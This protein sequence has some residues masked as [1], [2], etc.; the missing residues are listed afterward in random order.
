MPTRLIKTLLHAPCRRQ[1]AM[2]SRYLVAAIVTLSLFTTSHSIP[3]QVA[4]RATCTLVCPDVD[5]SA[6][7]NTHR[8][9]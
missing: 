3:S 8:C 5:V 1:D 7:M 9:A 2:F 6:T 4:R